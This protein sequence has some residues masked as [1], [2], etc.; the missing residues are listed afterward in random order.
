MIFHSRVLSVNYSRKPTIPDLAIWAASILLFATALHAG[1]SIRTEF[2]LKNDGITDSNLILTDGSNLSLGFQYF[3]TVKLFGDSFPAGPN[4]TNCPDIV[5]DTGSKFKVFYA[6][7]TEKGIFMTN[8]ELTNYGTMPIGEP[9]RICDVDVPPSDYYLHAD[10][11]EN[12]YLLS[13]V[14]SRPIA[15]RF[16]KIHNSI[17]SLTVDSAL[18]TGW[19]YPSQCSMEKDTFLLVS[20]LDYSKVTL[21]KIFS[22]DSI[23]S[24][25]GKVDIASGAAIQGNALMNCSVAY[26]G[27]GNVLVIWIRGSPNDDKRIY[28]QFF[29]RD[30]SAGPLDSIPELVSNKS[31]WFYDDA[32]TASYGEGKFAVVFWNSNGLFMY[33]LELNGGVVESTPVQLS[34]NTGIKF[35]AAASNKNFLLITC[36]GDLNNDGITSIEGFRF[37]VTGEVLGPAE[38]FVFSKLSKSVS[39]INKYST[40]V[41][42]ALNSTGDFGITWRDSSWVRGCFWGYRG[43]RYPSSFWTSPVDSLNVNSGDSVRFYRDSITVSSLSSWYIQDS[44]RVAC[45]RE[46]V[47]SAPWLPFQNDSVLALT[48]GDCKYFQYRFFLNR[49]TDIAGDSLS[50]PIISQISI[51][52]NGKP[53]I[54]GIDSVRTISSTNRT[55]S[56]DDT[57]LVISRKDTANIFVEYYDPDSIDQLTVRCSS[58]FNESISLSS[59]PDFHEMFTADPLVRSDTLVVCTLTVHDSRNWQAVPRTF[60]IRTR[61][62]APILNIR[63]AFTSGSGQRDTADVG[64]MY[65]VNLQEDDS[66]EF[67]YTVSDTNDPVSAQAFIDRQTGNG[68]QRIDSASPGYEK[69]FAIRGDTLTILDS[70]LLKFSA[71][72]QDTSFNRKVKFVVNHFPQIHSLTAGGNTVKN[73][74]SV[75]VVPGQSMQIAVAVSDTDCAFWDTLTYMFV[76]GVTVHSLVLDSNRHLHSYTPSMTDSIV[77]AIVIDRFGKRD[78]LSFFLKF[79]WFDKRKHTIPE[80]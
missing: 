4:T 51:P 75:R 57:I 16:L 60:S 15:K 10:K 8:V 63:A 7:S 74:D 37:P 23:I 33:R 31:Q 58:P 46:G 52:W 38:Q 36:K 6:D 39:T 1:T 24:F 19:L 40:A 77:H 47:S 44:I 11:G 76:S 73:G 27:N 30:L 5:P 14:N 25:K 53:A 54:S 48:K 42:C 2:S 17:C 49:R 64:V 59:G 67:Y 61:N 69:R 12:G 32:A 50:S 70:F 55:F 34:A 56:L 45:S 41:N 9:V 71:Q 35:C 3:Q 65:Y 66:I 13:F 29:G 79:P 62:S 72:D 21:R 68:T 18:N 80:C 43:I 28:Y 26:D 22:R 78:S 20:S